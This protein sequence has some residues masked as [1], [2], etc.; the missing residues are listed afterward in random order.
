VENDKEL[1]TVRA[2]T[3]VV[4]AKELRKKGWKVLESK[5]TMTVMR[6]TMRKGIRFFQMID[7][8]RVSTS[9]KLVAFLM[10]SQFTLSPVKV[11][12]RSV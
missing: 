12:D 6:M 4:A 5:F 10:L 9:P 11:N 8:R 2:C 1:E 7:I 3:I